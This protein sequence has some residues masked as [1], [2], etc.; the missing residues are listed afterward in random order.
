MLKNYFIYIF[1]ILLF[2]GCSNKAN[3]FGPYLSKTKNIQFLI[4]EGK[5]NWEKSVSPNEASQSRVFL[6]KAYNLDPNNFEVAV[7]YARSCYFI[8]HYIETEPIKSDS[9]FLEGMNTAWDFII[10]TD[11]YQEGT[12]LVEGHSEAKI[13]GGIENISQDLIPLIYWWTANYARYLITK[14][15]MY[16]LENRDKIESALHRVISF[17]PDYFYHGANRIFGGMYARLPGVDLIHAENNFEKSIEGSPN[18]FSTYVVRAQY[19]HTKN[20]NREKFIQDLQKILNMDPT[21][22]PEVSPENLFEQENARNLLSKE[23]SLF[24]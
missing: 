23:N 12:A 19:L 6:S 4:K 21:V 17:K 2:Y 5:A 8:G 9:L 7:L 13:I 18:Y 11:S 16:R 14:P 22:L 1:I 20:G 10:S 24:K 3:S 15:V